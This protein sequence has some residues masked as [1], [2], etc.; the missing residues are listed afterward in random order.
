MDDAAPEQIGI[1]WSSE[2]AVKRATAAVRAPVAADYK[3]M[4][5]NEEQ[6]KALTGK[7]GSLLDIMATVE[8]LAPYQRRIAKMEAEH[9]VLVAKLSRHRRNRAWKGRLPRSA[10]KTFAGRCADC[11]TI[12]APRR[13][14]CRASRGSCLSNRSRGTG[15]GVRA[16]CDPLPPDN[17]G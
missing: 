12:C 13:A 4:G 10:R 8:N 14:C 5:T 11:W 17:R 3:R 6:V 15:S 9:A 1:D 2:A 16:V 7:I